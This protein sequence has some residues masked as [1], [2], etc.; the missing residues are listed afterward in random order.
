M[1]IGCMLLLLKASTGTSIRWGN[2]SE[3][4]N[5]AGLHI[6]PN[7]QIELESE[8]GETRGTLGRPGHRHDC[9][10]DNRPVPPPSDPLTGYCCDTYCGCGPACA[11]GSDSGSGVGSLPRRRERTRRRRSVRCHKKNTESL[12]AGRRPQEQTIRGPQRR[13]VVQPHMLVGVLVGLFQGVGRAGDVPGVYAR[14]NQLAKARARRMGNNSDVLACCALG[15]DLGQR[16]HLHRTLSSRPK[17][18]VSQ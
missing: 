12:D 15:T 1:H 16:E 2:V 4:G 3:E 8:P 18:R 5:T 11:L 13:T 9:T 17:A 7:T 10:C 14:I 6:A